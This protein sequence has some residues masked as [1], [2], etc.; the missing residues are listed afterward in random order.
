[1]IPASKSI[2]KLYTHTYYI[3]EDDKVIVEMLKGK[4]PADAKVM[5]K[6]EKPVKE[7]SGSELLELEPGKLP[8]STD[9][10]DTKTVTLMYSV[11]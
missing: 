3:H 10:G 6:W 2:D 9:D 7:L 1:M 8:G 4:T 11:Q 5:M